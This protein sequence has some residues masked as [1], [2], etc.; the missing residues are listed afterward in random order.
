MLFICVIIVV[1]G[2]YLI[3]ITATSLSYEICFFSNGG[4]AQRPRLLSIVY[5]SAFGIMKVLIM[6]NE[7]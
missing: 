3:Q 2:N 6:I 5:A 4:E 1:P 7:W